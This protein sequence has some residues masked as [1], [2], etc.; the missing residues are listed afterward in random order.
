MEAKPIRQTLCLQDNVDASILEQLPATLQHDG[1]I[2]D[3]ENPGHDKPP[4]S[5]S[6]SRQR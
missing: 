5:S 3:D 2:V 1:M 4:T 6:S